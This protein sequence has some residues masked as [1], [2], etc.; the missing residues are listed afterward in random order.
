MKESDRRSE[1]NSEK[2]S[3]VG[4][5]FNYVKLFT[6][7]AELVS[8]FAYIFSSTCAR[9]Q[10]VRRA[11]LLQATVDVKSCSVTLSS[12]LIL[13]FYQLCQDII[14]RSH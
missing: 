13:C 10:N 2:D 5:I 12:F 4:V 8:F 9:L 1:R 7:L 14:S 6:W 3:T 11:S